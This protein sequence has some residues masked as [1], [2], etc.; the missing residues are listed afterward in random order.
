MPGAKRASST[1]I[2]G[3]IARQVTWNA[4]QDRELRHQR[5]NEAGVS[6]HPVQ[7]SGPPRVT[8]FGGFSQQQASGVP[9]TSKLRHATPR[10]ARST[11][12]SDVGDI[13]FL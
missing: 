11:E 8:L 1:S 7:N 10:S 9:V 4:K 2:R 13:T 12:L 6:A 5:G 3:W